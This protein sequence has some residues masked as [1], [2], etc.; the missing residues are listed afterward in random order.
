MRAPFQFVYIAVY[1]AICQLMA[2]GRSMSD[3]KVCDNSVVDMFPKT[4]QQ[5][6][7]ET[8]YRRMARAF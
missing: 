8:L 3:L 2:I 5:S 4:G 7:S 6:L 1:Q